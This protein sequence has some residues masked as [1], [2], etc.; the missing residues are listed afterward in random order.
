MAEDHAQHVV[1][2]VGDASRQPADRFHLLGLD[3]LS[4]QLLALRCG[5]PTLGDVH[6]GAQHAQRSPT[7]VAL[8][9]PPGRL[10]PA[11]FP[12]GRP[13]AELDPVLGNFPGEVPEVLGHHGLAI[14]GMHP[15]EPGIG[16]LPERRRI[17]AHHCRVA[18]AYVRFTRLD[19][20]VEDP[21][22]RRFEGPPQPLLTL[23]QCRVGL[24]AAR[25]ADP[26][27]GGKPAL[28]NH[29]HTGENAV[30]QSDCAEY[31]DQSGNG[32][33]RPHE[34]EDTQQDGH[35]TAHDEDPPVPRPEC[36]HPASICSF[37]RRVAIHG[38]PL[39]DLRAAVPTA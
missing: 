32:R 38:R 35:H 23:S 31:E 36:E 18:G 22:V 19:V 2:V 25:L 15:L 20:V 24:L 16:R 13:L 10:D 8:H 33:E 37:A 29:R 5:P 26:S 30:G 4:L 14:V 17:V 39:I 28:G 12:G 1:E 3:E 7:S 34:G 6:V 27:V 21:L 9:D 11:P